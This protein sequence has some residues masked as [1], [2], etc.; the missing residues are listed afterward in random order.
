MGLWTKSL[1]VFGVFV[2]GPFYWL[3][4]DTSTANV[5]ARS[6]DMAAL[7]QVAQEKSGPKPVSIEFAAVAVR[8]I[9]GSYLVAGGGLKRDLF[10]AVAFRLIAP[11]GDT[12]IDSGLNAPQSDAQRFSQWDGY[13][14]AAVSRWMHDAKSI[15]F[16]DTDV[17]H[18]G[19]FVTS[20]DFQKIAGKVIYPAEMAAS[21]RAGLGPHAPSL[22]APKV[23][24]QYFAVAPGVVLM[25]A[26][27]HTR[28]SQMVFVQLQNGKEY[29]FTGD[30]APMWRNVAWKRPRSR[31]ASDW[32]KGDNRTQSMGWI[33]ALAALTVSE[34]RLT[35]VHPHDLAW[36]QS[37]RRG[38][39][40]TTSFHYST[41]DEDRVP[42]DD[43][44]PGTTSKVP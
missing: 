8:R 21:L 23:T 1:I 14:Q 16:T 18:T 42:G 24:G 34:P 10:A 36:L 20:P 5:P 37:E 44:L 25:R 26:P 30:A 33:N 2:G 13:A 41:T 6:I 4:I 11:G 3:L 22:A 12:V 40:F 43:D 32:F 39:Q 35:L 28:A 15:V 27:G 19:G 17:E 31:L 38:P 29:L 7:R 9:P